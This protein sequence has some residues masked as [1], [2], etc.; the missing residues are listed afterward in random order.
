MAASEPQKDPWLA[1]NLT[2][3]FLP[4]VEVH[5]LSLLE[6]GVAVRNVW[7]KEC[8]AFRVSSELAP[9]SLRVPY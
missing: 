9:Y 6:L 5:S 1:L 8:E 7:T 4:P 3:H 2:S